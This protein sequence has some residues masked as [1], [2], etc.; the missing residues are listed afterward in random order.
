MKP[1]ELLLSR[2]T[3]LKRVGGGWA[4]RCPAHD[5]KKP[6]LSV[7]EGD[8]GRALV[9]CHAGCTVDAIAK[10]LG[11]ALRDLMPE[12]ELPRASPSPKPLPR[13]RSGSSGDGG[14]SKVF[15]TAADAVAELERRHGP[16]SA[17]WVYEAADGTPLGVVVRWNRSG[18]R[19]DIRPVSRT[20]AGWIIGGMPLPR[21]L[22]RLPMLAGARR[23]YVTEGEKAAEAVISL[24]LVTT[25]SPHGAQSANA[26]DWSPLAGKEIVIL[27]DNDA[28]GRKYASEVVRL[29]TRLSPAP[30][31]KVLELDDLP[32]GGDAFDFIESYRSAGA[33]ADEQIKTHIERWADR[34]EPV[35]AGESAPN[36]ERFQPF[37]VSVLPEPLCSFVASSATAIGCDASYVALPLLAALAA[38]IGNSRRI[39]LKRGWSEP[40]IVWAVIVGESGTQKTPA[41][42]LVLQP[43]RDLQAKAMKAHVAALGAY[44]VDALRY[45]KKL[46]EWKRCKNESDPPEKPQP[47]AAVR[48]VISDTTVEALAP[49]LLA[50][51]RGVLLA[52]D[53]IGG[54]LGSFDRYSGGKGGADEAHW[55]SM[56]GGECLVVDRKTGAPRTIYIPSAAVSVTGGIQPGI[57]DRA[58]GA[59]HRESGL[60]ARLLLAMPPRR[61][62][63]WTEAE[64]SPLT[65]AALLAI[66]ERLY[67]LDF[68]RDTDGDSHPITLPL[69]SAGRGAWINFYNEHGREQADLTGDLS[70]AWSKLEGYAARLALVMHCV[71]W[72]AQDPTLSDDNAIDEV[73]VAAGVELSRWFGHEARRVYSILTEDDEARD[74]RRLVEW[75]ERRGGGISLRELTHGMRQYRGNTEAARAVLNTLAKAGL[76]HWTHPAPGSAGGRPSPRFELTGAAP[77]IETPAG[78]EEGEGIGDR[79]SDA[80]PEGASWGDCSM[81]NCAAIAAGGDGWGR[82]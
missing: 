42:R 80:F 49:I 82:L 57:L 22:Y 19:K 34:I 56:H 67:E 20:P 44:E 35:E 41:F 40:A 58:L 76:G 78:D 43:L 13:R 5:D 73:S 68:A 11:L 33:L 18:G 21:P 70:A 1:V 8:D 2:L 24:G 45:E 10:A 37:P 17:W 26:A 75:I 3:K 25:T 60:L 38:A 72:A 69:S 74:R 6:S 23:V 31:V 51:P 65:E 63:L 46:A 28:A 66:F 30:T 55:L 59:E 77:V 29:L 48:M 36:S 16:R 50:N 79:D 81:D 15:A 32:P 39:Q 62:K 47:P 4:A 12:R 27:P 53:E 71:R 52:R 7:S 64:I 9:H 61:A 54:W 14:S